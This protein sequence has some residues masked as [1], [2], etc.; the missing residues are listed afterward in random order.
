MSE[1]T[2]AQFA[3]VLKVPVDRLLVQLESAGIQVEGPQALI[4]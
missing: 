1:V 3:E 2:V 4:S